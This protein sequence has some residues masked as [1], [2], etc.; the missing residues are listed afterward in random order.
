MVLG[1]LADTVMPDEVREE[2]EQAR[3]ERERQEE[4]ER[5]KP[6]REK[7]AGNK[8]VLYR[9]YGVRIQVTRLR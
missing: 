2:Q 5:L 7:L 9:T 8:A 4:Q 6:A 3:L 1:S